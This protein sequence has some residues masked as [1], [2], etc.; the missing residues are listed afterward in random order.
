MGWLSWANGLIGSW[1]G[2]LVGTWLQFLVCVCVCVCVELELVVVGL[3][4]PQVYLV[5]HFLIFLESLWV[6]CW[7]LKGPKF[8]VNFR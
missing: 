2:W 1:V 4:A 6:G 8:Q 7:V 5:D 3:M